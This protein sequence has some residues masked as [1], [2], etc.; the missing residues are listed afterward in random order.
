MIAGLIAWQTLVHTGVLLTV[1]GGL[2]IGVA[3]YFG[4][5]ALLKVD[6]LQMLKALVRK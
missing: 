5:C 3:L 1:A 6:E 4:M 2:A